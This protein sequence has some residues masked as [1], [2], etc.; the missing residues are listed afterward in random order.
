MAI[1]EA[2]RG[3]ERDRERI[4]STERKQRITPPPHRRPHHAGAVFDRTAPAPAVFSKEDFA[5]TQVDLLRYLVTGQLVARIQSGR[6]LPPDR[7]VVTT[8]T[9]LASHRVGCDWLDRIRIAMAARGL[10][11]EIYDVATSGDGSGL[12]D[13]L[14]ADEGSAQMEALRARCE[15]YLQRLQRS[16]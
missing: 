11:C 10:A 12:A 9:W 4:A 1:A 7:V 2:Q 6:W 3:P 16:H 8:R 14:L 15:H 5:V 13:G